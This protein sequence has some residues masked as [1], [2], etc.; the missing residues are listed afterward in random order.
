MAI[1]S[2]LL[3]HGSY[4]NLSDR[5]RR[6]LLIQVNGNGTALP[7]AASRFTSLKN[8]SCRFKTKAVVW[9]HMYVISD[10]LVEVMIVCS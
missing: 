2:Y 4:P 5:T 6:M 1:F 10:N 3:I 9:I 8:D 7:L